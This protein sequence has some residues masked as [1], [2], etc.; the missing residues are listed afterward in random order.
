MFRTVTAPSFRLALV[1]ASGDSA[2]LVARLSSA[3]LVVDDGLP[4]D[5]ADA[6]LVLGPA[7]DGPLLGAAD[8]GTPVLL[9]GLRH[10][11][12]LWDAAGLL[13]GRALPVHEVRVRPGRDARE[14]A[15]RLGG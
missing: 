7:P 12:A 15:R 13:P 6:V 2:P 3:G 10:S 14:V 1:G 5:G 11:G 9:V 8:R 4:A